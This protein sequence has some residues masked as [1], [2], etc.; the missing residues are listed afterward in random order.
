MF[1]VNCQGFGWC[2]RFIAGVL[3]Q[4][5]VSG[6]ASSFVARVLLQLCVSG[7]VPSATLPPADRRLHMLLPHGA[8]L[9]C[10]GV[11]RC[12]LMPHLAQAKELLKR[13]WQ[14]YARLWRSYTAARML[15][16][17]RTQDAA[18][19]FWVCSCMLA[20]RVALHGHCRRTA[21]SSALAE[22]P[23][24]AHHTRL[25][26]TCCAIGCHRLLLRHGAFW[27]EWEVN[28]NTVG[29]LAAWPAATPACA[30]SVH[31]SL[32]IVSQ[33]AS[34]LAFPPVLLAFPQVLKGGA[35]GVLRG[36]QPAA[37]RPSR[38]LRASSSAAQ[39]ALVDSL[40]HNSPLCP[41]GVDTYDGV[42]NIAGIQYSSVMFIG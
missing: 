40:S 13:N 28:Y 9:S 25:P 23:T 17:V 27:F 19:C 1:N 10:P 39:C 4:L 32:S 16:T 3:L 41:A 35:S 38:L 8:A 34:Q 2:H 12:S 18:A 31:A 21:C 36:L 26:P 42:L 7:G 20:T 5:G 15:I 24:P 33:P 14:Q 6:G 30:S 22:L 37:G 11:S 29:A